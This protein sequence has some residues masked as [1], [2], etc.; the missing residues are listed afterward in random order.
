MKQEESEKPKKINQKNKV[1]RKRQ[2]SFITVF[3]W[4]FLIATMITITAT[5]IR[6]RN[7][8]E[9]ENSNWNI[10]LKMYDKS[11]DM[12]NEAIENIVWDKQSGEV[13]IIL[14]KIDF[15]GYAD[16]TYEPGEL[17]IE[18][19]TLND[20]DIY[21]WSPSVEEYEY[22]EYGWGRSEWSK[23]SPFEN[24]YRIEEGYKVSG[25]IQIAMIANRRRPE[26]YEL[27]AIMSENGSTIAKSNKCT[28]KYSYN[29][30]LPNE[31]LN[32][33]LLAN[34]SDNSFLEWREG[35]YNT[36]EDQYMIHIRNDYRIVLNGNQIENDMILKMYT[37]LPSEAN[38]EETS[39]SLKNDLRIN[40]SNHYDD[41]VFEDVLNEIES[42]AEVN[43]IQ[44]YNDTGETKIEII[45]DFNRLK[46]I[47]FSSDTKYV[48]VRCT[49]YI[50]IDLESIKKSGTIYQIK[51]YAMWEEQELYTYSHNLGVVAKDVYDIDNDG[52]VDEDMI[53]DV[54]VAGINLYKDIYINKEWIGNN[55]ENRPESITVVLKAN[56]EV[57]RE[58]EITE[59]DHWRARILVDIFDENG[60]EIN[61]TVEEKNVANYKTT[62]ENYQDEFN[63]LN[64]YFDSGEKNTIVIKK[65]WEDNNNESRK[66]TKKN[67][68]T[69]KRWARSSRRG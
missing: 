58:E 63:I 59:D 23:V 52:N 22:S 56:G 34:G 4:L 13:G 44:N 28:F 61:Y 62:I 54:Q 53:S 42:N 39:A 67:N 32:E 27:E 2:T 29:K 6:N 16:K 50:S 11:S 60:N 14:L 26:T 35:S 8:L 37:I 10:T 49:S 5:G 18:V 30:Y 21:D 33:I 41:E 46:D 65:I 19:P 43:I 69:T 38:L 17:K 51:R 1:K 20:A 64:E 7:A 45:I 57:I 66:E 55:E 36:Y 31:D 25:T 68:Y 9:A 47:T 24:T 15:S 3:L 48:S 40:I 12:P